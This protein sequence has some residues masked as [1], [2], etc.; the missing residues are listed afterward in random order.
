MLRCKAVFGCEKRRRGLI[1]MGL[2]KFGEQG[3]A[4]FLFSNLKSKFKKV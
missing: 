2:S 4:I 1:G 3:Y